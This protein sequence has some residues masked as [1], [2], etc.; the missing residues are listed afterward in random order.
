VSAA[1]A[2]G[3][4][5]T[6]WRRLAAAPALR[7]VVARTVSASGG[8]R[9]L[10]GV[11]GLVRGGFILAYHNPS[12]ALVAA[13]VEALAPNRPVSLGELLARRD[14]GRTTRG[15]FA[16]TFDDGV[17][18]TVRA[19]AALARVRAW[20]VTFY[21]PTA[22][23]DGAVMPF[24]I[25]K[26][27]GDC[28]PARRELRAGAVA[29]EA[30]EGAHAFLRRVQHAMYTRPAG[31]YLPLLAELREHLVAAGLIDAGALATPAPITWAEVTELARDPRV[32]FE[33]H[34]VSHSALSALAGPE[35]EHELA[36]SRDTIRERTGRPCEHF[37]YP[38]GAAESIGARAP[39]VVARF[40][41]SA[42]TMARGR[43]GGHDRYLLP[44]IP[45]Y[46][47]DTPEV[48]RL[49]VLTP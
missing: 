18:E 17:G 9:V 10:D 22:Y 3:G 43:V 8:Y 15:L 6:R 41:R 38:F 40:Y 32:G 13:H 44:R 36:H 11:L 23:L 45:L 34:G 1:S 30:A 5:P 4:G 24:Q 42:T 35:L 31:E 25:L 48:A 7:G 27:L 46:P 14:G 21:L 49:K 2:N 33:S 16:L 26:A 12:A 37:C 47:D 19:I 28:L 20:P 29:A 39:A